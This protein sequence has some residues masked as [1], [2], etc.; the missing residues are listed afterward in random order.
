MC[1]R[2]LSSLFVVV[3]IQMS[4][5]FS[6]SEKKRYTT[7]NAWTFVGQCNQYSYY[8]SYLSTRGTQLWYH[9]LAAGVKYG[10]ALVM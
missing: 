7:K 6:S 5:V 10:D 3:E 9:I 4:E 1:L 2:I 8:V